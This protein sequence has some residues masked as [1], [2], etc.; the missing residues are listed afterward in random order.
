MTVNGDRRT[1]ANPH[2]RPWYDASMAA[3]RKRRIVRYLAITLALA[4]AALCVS[5]LYSRQGVDHRL[6]GTWS[7]TP[8][9]TWRLSGNGRGELLG[10][11]NGEWFTALRYSWSVS[12]MQLKTTSYNDERTVPGRIRRECQIVWQKLKGEP[13]WTERYDLLEIRPDVITLKD[14][15]GKRLAMRRRED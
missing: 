13:L 7:V 5:R 14:E 9:L 11:R 12:G 2:T 6:V 3:P 10:Y 4:V 15:N 1:L 8:T